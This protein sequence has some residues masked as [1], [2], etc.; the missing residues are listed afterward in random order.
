ML[1][2]GAGNAGACRLPGSALRLSVLGDWI[3]VGSSPQGC[4]SNFQKRSSL[5]SSHE[6]Q[7]PMTASAKTPDVG[8]L[9][10][11]GSAG[12]AGAYRSSKET[13]LRT[14]PPPSSAMGS[15]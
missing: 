2:I 3:G 6:L 11:I 15:S 9:I 1:M 8:T 14:L 12:D 5:I 4:S 13:V 10:R 7:E